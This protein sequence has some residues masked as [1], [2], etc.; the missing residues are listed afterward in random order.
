MD[1]TSL[2]KVGCLGALCLVFFI[3]Y[4]LMGCCAISTNA[5]TLVRLSIVVVLAMFFNGGQTMSVWGAK[6]SLVGLPLFS[7]AIVS[8]IG[9]PLFASCTLS[10]NALPLCDQVVLSFIGA[11]LNA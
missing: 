8:F 11:S 1:P 4:P 3:Y 2:L 6:F 5:F 7:G 10:F 9:L